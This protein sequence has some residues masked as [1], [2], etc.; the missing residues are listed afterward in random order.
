MRRRLTFAL[1]GALVVPALLAGCGGKKTAATTTAP[2]E[3]KN[4]CVVVTVSTRHA[5]A[6]SSPSRRCSSRR[7]SLRR[8]DGD[9]LRQLHDPDGPG[10]V[11]ERG[12]VVRRRSS[13]RGFFDQTVFH[14]IV[15][16]FVIQGGDPTATGTGGPGLL[17]RRHAA[18]EREVHARRRRDGEDRQP[19]RAGTAGA[20]SSSSR[21]RTPASRPTTRS[22]ARS[23]AASR[24]R[25]HRDARRRLAAADPGRRDPA[26][27][28]QVH[29]G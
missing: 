6:T 19:S 29:V 5:G 12:G 23:S 26:G 22:S 7:T 24:R 21:S 27:H 10:A 9:E 11:A 16:G 13:Q 3:K 1:A 4:G 14:R 18:E 2:V 17:D 15:P 8:H 25:P 20:S 28:G